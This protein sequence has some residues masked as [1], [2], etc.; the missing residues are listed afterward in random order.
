[1]GNGNYIICQKCEYE[2]EF[3]LGA[4]MLWGNIENIIGFMDKRSKEELFSIELVNEN[5]EKNY[6][7]IERNSSWL[8]WRLMECPYKKDIYFFE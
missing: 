1:M 8:H 6:P 2:R 7:L 3:L 5:V 4:G